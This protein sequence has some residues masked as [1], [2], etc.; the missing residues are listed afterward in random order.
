MNGT[1]GNFCLE[2]EGNRDRSKKRDGAWSSNVGHY[3][4]VFDNEVEVLRYDASI[5]V[6][7]T[8]SLNSV[9]SN[10]PQF[11]TYLEKTQPRAGLSVITHAIRVFRQ[12]RSAMDTGEGSDP[13]IPF[14]TLLASATDG[15]EPKAVDP[16]KWGLPSTYNRS[17]E[18]ISE[19]DWTILLS[20]LLNGRRF[21]SLVL[22]P[23]LLLRHAAGQLFQE[24]HYE[25]SVNRQL[26]LQGFEPPAHKPLKQSKGIGVHFTPP[27]LA[28][29]VVEQCIRL[30]NLSSTSLTV[31]DPACG[32]GEF[33]RESFR[34]LRLAGFKNSIKLIGWDISQSACEMASFVLA[35]EE[36]NDAGT[37]QIEITAQNSLAQPNWP[38]DIDLLVMNPPFV[39][40]EY[41]TKEQLDT[42]H[43]ILGPLAKG[44]ADLSTAFV[45]KAANALSNAAVLGAVL[46][47]SFLE[48]AA[49]KAVRD[50]IANGFSLNLLARLG[51]QLL[52]SDALVDAAALIG[53]KGGRADDEGISFWADYRASST[54]AGL[55]ELRR[56]TQTGFT[57]PIIA[58]GFSIYSRRNQ[59]SETASWAP[60]SYEAW[61]LAASLVNQPTVNELFDVK[62]GARSG[63]KKAFILPKNEWQELPASE[64]KYFRPVVV[65]TSIVNG[66]LQ[67]FYYM[68]FPYGDRIISS[69]TELE[70]K[71]PRYFERVLKPLEPQLRRRQSKRDVERWWEMSE[72]RTW[73]FVREPKLISVSYGDA[74]SFAYDESGDFVVSQGYCWLPRKKVVGDKGFPAKLA[75][76]YVAVLNSPIT[77]KLLPASSSQVQGGQWDLRLVDS[78][79][80]PDLFNGRDFDLINALASIGQA[81][82]AGNPV[83]LVKLQ[84]AAA[85]AYGIGA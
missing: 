28:R 19:N 62:M 78:M 20:E 73:Q 67:D 80:L 31:F 69:E 46:P 72:P 11:H 60:R 85:A 45:W 9:E 75:R 41:L 13:I 24:A 7:E 63:H 54:S 40:Y 17:I 49:T 12:L 79:P 15:L 48:G 14:L 64:R 71:L 35:W 61:Q 8:Y 76:A 30:L 44:R 27:S 3:V 23:D 33:L 39:S 50:E 59:Q 10:L 58:D 38:K 77:S 52:F 55:R 22:L 34:Q 70:R 74:G 25:A 4:S 53:Q 32:S 21:D 2:V 82:G 1:S 6:A 81:M 16:I 68:F 56:A 37:L 18:L 5:A 83:D 66:L 26:R 29:M 36:R 57:G 42:I 65:N 84:E 47:S 43:S 51:S